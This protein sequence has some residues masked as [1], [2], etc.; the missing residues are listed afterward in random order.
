[1]HFANRV[2]ELAQ[3]EKIP[4]HGPR[5]PSLAVL[6]GPGG[7]GKSAVALHWLDQVLDRFPDGQLYATLTQPSGDPVAV[8]DILGEFLRALGVPAE[9]VPTTLSERAA[10]YRS[11]TASR[12]IA[13]LLDDAMSAAQVRTLL[14]ASG[15]CTVTV[16]SRRALVGLLPEGASVVVVAPLEPPAAIELIRRHVGTERLA[17]EPIST[18][19][20]VE[21]CAGLPIALCVAAALMTLRPKR[22]VADLVGALRD[23][24]QRLNV[25]SVADDLSV[26]ST[27]DLSYRT[28]PTRAVPAY[29]AVGVHPGT[30]ISTDLVAATCDISPATAA[31]A[32]EDLVAASLVD[33]VAE[34]LYHRHDLVRDHARAVAEEALPVARRDTMR[35]AAMEWHLFAA[36]HADRI[37]MPARRVLPYRFAVQ[38]QP[39]AQVDNHAAAL[40]WLERHRLDLAATVRAAHDDGYHALAYHL[41]DAMQPLFVLHKHYSEAVDVYSVGMQAAIWMRDVGAEVNMRTRHARVLLHLTELDAAERQI[42][43]LLDVA[44]ARGNRRN[45]ASAVKTLGGLHSR[46]ERHDEAV[47][48]FEEALTIVHDLGRRRAEGLVRIDLGRELARLGRHDDAI[49]RLGEARDILGALDPADPYAAARASIELARTYLRHGEPAT[50]RRFLDEALPKVIAV[51]SPHEA[52]H[53]HQALEA[54]LIASG[55]TDLAE[56]HR[57]QAARLLSSI[58]TALID[59]ELT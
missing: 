54:T 45:Q 16:T 53:V 4:R 33:E 41:C 56:V 11:L 35:L 43:E 59:D 37:V 50:A 44:Y 5:T 7:V 57:E 27:F 10:L 51:G 31:T 29:H 17:A 39:P 48:A 49:R 28:L 8:D 22:T 38:H 13:V 55:D 52:A 36:Q 3:L 20:L 23:E 21:L 12:S 47:L 58:D 15:S 2:S 19:S 30:V 42:R 1:V 34:R 32:I 9:Q 24:R 26:R 46:R 25:L 18:T 14:P 6:T 40:A